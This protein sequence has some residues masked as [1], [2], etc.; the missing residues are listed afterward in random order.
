MSVD[1]KRAFVLIVMSLVLG[2]VACCSCEGQWGK[3]KWIKPEPEGPTPI[4]NCLQW[5]G[6]HDRLVEHQVGMLE[7]AHNVTEWNINKGS[8]LDQNTEMQLLVAENLRGRYKIVVLDIETLHHKLAAA[9]PGESDEQLYAREYKIRAHAYRNFKSVLGDRVAVIQY[10][11]RGTMANPDASGRY[12][13]DPTISDGIWLSRYRRSNQTL[14]T[15]LNTL[16]RDYLEGLRAAGN[17][18]LYLNT[19]FMMFDDLSSTMDPQEFGEALSYIDEHFELD[20]IALWF[21][22]HQRYGYTKGIPGVRECYEMI[23]QYHANY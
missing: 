12:F 19:S 7:T 20:G 21:G 14:D 1:G 15:Y 2:T 3:G 18:P 4:Y 8:I 11:Q 16:T 6:E 10:N 9:Y 13:A 22:F 23:R 17:R 5:A